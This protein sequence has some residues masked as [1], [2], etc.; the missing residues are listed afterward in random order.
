MAQD[1]KLRAGCVISMGEGLDPARRLITGFQL[2]TWYGARQFQCVQ[3]S[4]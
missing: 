1:W 3:I 2:H 4:C